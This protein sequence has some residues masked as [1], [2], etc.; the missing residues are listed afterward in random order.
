M[1]LLRGVILQLAVL[2]KTHRERLPCGVQFIQND[3]QIKLWIRRKAIE[4]V[5]SVNRNL[6]ARWCLY[7]DWHDLLQHPWVGFSA[8]HA[9][10]EQIAGQGICRL[11]IVVDSNPSCLSRLLS[12]SSL[13]SSPIAWSGPTAASTVPTAPLTQ[14]GPMASPVVD[15]ASR[16]AGTTTP[17]AEAAAVALQYNHSS[18]LTKT[19]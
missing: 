6:Q 2:T 16:S 1:I 14:W 11:A 17:Q 4:C 3:R 8:A 18:C 15:F 9:A 13:G 5:H 12:R 10:K 7:W 19:D